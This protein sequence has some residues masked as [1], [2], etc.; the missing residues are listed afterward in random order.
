[1]N[2]PKD[3]A[4]EL[5]VMAEKLTPKKNPE[6][7]AARQAEQALVLAERKAADKQWADARLAEVR[8]GIDA[9][10]DGPSP[11]EVG[12]RPIA[13]PDALRPIGAS[14]ERTRLE[15]RRT[16]IRNDVSKI[17]DASQQ[18]R[19]MAELQRVE[20]ELRRAA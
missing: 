18:K 8:A 19:L 13:S 1:M 9:F 5:K 12:A 15:Q 14:A 16:M 17:R 11:S 20:E 10:F 4:R 2:A 7:T 3:A 6:V